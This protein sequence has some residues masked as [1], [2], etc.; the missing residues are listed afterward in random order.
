MYS[1]CAAGEKQHLKA[2]R[3]AGGPRK[4]KKKRNLVRQ[5]ELEAAAA[6]RFR[7]ISVII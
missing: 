6:V 5:P 7:P 3:V 2:K 1:A 4:G